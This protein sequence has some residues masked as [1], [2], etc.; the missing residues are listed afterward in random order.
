MDTNVRV[1]DNAVWPTKD[2]GDDGLLL[3]D[4]K[5]NVLLVCYKVPSV[6]DCKTVL[7]KYNTSGTC[8]SC[9]RKVPLLD[10]PMKYI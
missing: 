2:K 4:K 6:R 7:S 8:S 10:R 9:V 3:K 5:G 1:C